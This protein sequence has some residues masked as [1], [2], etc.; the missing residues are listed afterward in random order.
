[1]DNRIKQSRKQEKEFAKR[2]SGKTTVS[3]GNK[4]GAKGD[5]KTK[6]FLVELKRTDHDSYSFSGAVWNKIRKEAIREGLREPMYA[7][8]I[9]GLHL[10]AVDIYCYLFKYRKPEYSLIATPRLGKRTATLNNTEFIQTH[11]WIKKVKGL[12]AIPAFRFLLS[13][14]DDD[15]KEELSFELLVMKEKDFF[16][17]LDL[18]DE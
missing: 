14:V 9:N 4:W 13:C 17:Y 5:V 15:S 16:E 3:S 12:N 10:V 8:E 11:Q 1:M 6:Y 18:P 7:V 2:N